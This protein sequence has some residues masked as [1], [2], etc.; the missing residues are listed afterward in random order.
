MWDCYSLTCCV[1][2]TFGSSRN[3]GS[4]SLFYKHSY[5]GRCSYELALKWY[6]FLNLEEGLPVI[7]KLRDFS[8]T[9]PR[10]YKNVYINSFFPL[11]ARLWNSRSVECF[12]LTEIICLQVVF[13]QISYLKIVCTSF[14]CNSV[15]RSGCSVLHG[16]NLN[17]K[18]PHKLKLS[19]TDIRQSR[20]TSLTKK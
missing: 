4:L 7:D 12:A 5:F 14:S 16:V 9:I 13:K 2:R 18:K 15:P 6:H 10:R 17:Y 3:V 8:A 19:V 11:R 20:H 1:S